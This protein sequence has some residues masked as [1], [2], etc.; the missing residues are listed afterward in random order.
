LRKKKNDRKKTETT[1]MT[2]VLMAKV[3]ELEYSEGLNKKPKILAKRLPLEL[4]R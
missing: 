1:S 2:T 3:I 4:T